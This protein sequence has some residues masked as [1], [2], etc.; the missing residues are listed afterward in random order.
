MSPA[1]S[2]RCLKG[3]LGPALASPSRAAMWTLRPGRSKGSR[4]FYV[5]T[6]SLPGRRGE[7]P[8]LETCRA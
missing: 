8:D 3:E 1:D 2:S 6:G 5:I 4:M 7:G